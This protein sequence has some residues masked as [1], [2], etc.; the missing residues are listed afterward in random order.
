[1][2]ILYRL[3]VEVRIKRT[4]RGLP[5]GEAE[6]RLGSVLEV[7]LGCTPETWN[8]NYPGSTEVKVNAQQTTALY[9][10]ESPDEAHERLCKAIKARGALGKKA[11]VR[12]SWWFDERDP[13]DRFE[14]DDFEEEG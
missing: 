11:R 4:A 6:S 3:L 12:T 7:E 2:S 14:D 9:S 5:S 13:D 8:W 1:M 10:G